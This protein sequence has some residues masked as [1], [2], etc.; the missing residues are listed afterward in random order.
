MWLVMPLQKA[1]NFTDAKLVKITKGRNK[2]RKRKQEA[3][4]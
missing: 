3:R 4:V 1:V 2:G